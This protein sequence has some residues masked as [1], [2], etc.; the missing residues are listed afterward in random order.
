MPEQRNGVKP[1]SEAVPSLQ[2]GE[3]SWLECCLLRVVS[4]EQ[5]GSRTQTLLVSG[6]PSFLFT[7]AE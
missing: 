3:F 1:V 6:C 4:L 7:I 5:G 2:L